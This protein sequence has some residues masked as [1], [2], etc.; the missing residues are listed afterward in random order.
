MYFFRSRLHPK[1]AAFAL[2]IL[3]LCYEFKEKES[4]K[5]TRTYDRD[6]PEKTAE[7]SFG[8]SLRVRLSELDR[9]RSLS[10]KPD[11]HGLHIQSRDPSIWAGCRAS[12][13]IAVSELS[14]EIKISY[15][16]TVLDEGIVRLGWATAD[17][18]LQ[19]GTDGDGWGYGS[20]GV[21]VHN[22]RYTPYKIS[23]GGNDE[24]SKIKKIPFGKDDVIGCH[25]HILPRI[26]D[27]ETDE[28]PHQSAVIS[29]TKNDEILRKAFEIPSSA[30]KRVSSL[31]PSVCMKN[32]ECVFSFH[33]EVSKCKT[34]PNYL[35]LGNIP[36]DELAFNPRDASVFRQ[37][38]GKQLKGP[39]AVVIEPTRD[40]A[41]Q[42]YQACVD[43]SQRIVPKVR[44]ALLVGG[45][46]PKRTLARLRANEV[47]VLVGT[48]P[49][50]A[51]YIRKEEIRVDRCRYFVLDE[52]DEL[53]GTD[54]VKNIRS[55]FSRL[56][57]AN[58]SRSRFERLQVCFFSATLESKEVRELSDTVCHTPSWIKLR[59]QK[60]HVLPETVHHCIV[61]VSPKS[62]K[63]SQVLLETDA[64]HRRGKLEEDV[65]FDGL[66]RDEVNSERVKQLKMS[67]LPN[68]LELFQ[69]DQVLIFCRT[70]LD[71]SLLENYL[72]RQ[73]SGDGIVDK[74]S[75]RVLAGSRTMDE[76]RK[77]LAEFKNGEARILIATDVAAR[78]ID[79]RELPYVINFT[80]PDCVDTYIHRS[81]RVGRAERI[82]LVIS[83]VATVQERVWYCQKGKK[84]PCD[85]TR[86]YDKGGTS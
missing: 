46:S 18:S 4:N 20:T 2:P 37:M 60:E 42:T 52:A 67:I 77:S 79:I 78:G 39:L 23:Q 8:S 70:N 47:D 28:S 32:A 66:N 50:I 1:T 44:S 21:L 15:F 63:K 68:L 36:G 72:R 9:D 83:L 7:C 26:E 12:S 6:N 81:G 75:C 71:C 51:S 54:T 59:D 80:L 74:Y 45:A 56:L 34:P 58:E 55:I 5:Q 49:I 24:T 53:I 33:E 17:A 43:L 62:F 30:L 57:A 85:D 10:I 41:E 14:K 82:G 64:V 31:Y 11:S 16:C 40:L 22:N 61:S 29:Y 84:P 35:L 48:P 76:R 13:G 86:D 3:Q 25:L 38:N 65:S 27:D 73:G 69:M 19:L